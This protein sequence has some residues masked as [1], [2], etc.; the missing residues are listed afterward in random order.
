MDLFNIIASS[1]FLGAIVHTFLAP[2]FAKVAKVFEANND[3]LVAKIFEICSEIE[4]VFFIW[5]L[6]LIALIYLAKGWPEVAAYFGTKVDYTEAVFVVAIMSI[7][8]TRPI[9]E[10]AKS[11][12]GKIAHKGG[13]T[14][15][16]WWLSI[17]ILGPLF[18]SFITEPAAM[19]IAAILLSKQ[20]YD[21]NPSD[22]L[23][24]ATLALLFV[25]IS[26]GGTL[27]NFAAPPIL[28]IAHQWNWSSSQIFFN[29]GIKAI[30]GII[31]ASSLYALLFKKEFQRLASV[32]TK[33]M[34]NKPQKIPPFITIIHILFLG[35]CIANAHSIVLLMGILLFFLGFL[36]ITSEYQY[37][38][39]LKN[40]LLVGIFLAGL[41]SHGNL[42][43]WWIEPL[44]GN[45]NQLQLFLGATLLTSFNDNAA[46][47]YLSSLVPKFA[48]DVM[49]QKAVI[50]GAVT[51]GGLTVIANAPNPAG[52]SIL[53]KYFHEISPMKLFSW[54]VIP[55]LILG[56]FLYF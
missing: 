37:K 30:I 1:I 53:G 31:V 28:M 52:Q 16:S 21:L 40:P 5:L 4:L 45:L 19:T 25:N 12:L 9:I 20:F 48:N 27:T 35:L 29:F 3:H 41:V 15:L 44:L 11:I 13:D 7:A 10:L 24:Y 34:D 56:L 46:I 55:T 39:E 42:Q 43:K 38:F 47:T 33:A 32:R 26:V 18:G 14:P 8:G 50:A 36:Q 17:M 22:S 51:G 23:K 2:K 54:A 49:L 6:P